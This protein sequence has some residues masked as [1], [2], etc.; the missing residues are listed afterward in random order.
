MS[1]VTVKMLFLSWVMRSG[2]H[3]VTWLVHC[4]VVAPSTACLPVLAPTRI[5]IAS[6]HY[7]HSRFVVDAQPSTLGAVPPSQ[8]V[9]VL[10]TETILS[11]AQSIG[12]SGMLP[13]IAW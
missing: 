4:S 13:S 2:W 5:D 7:T 10:S 6:W 11:G 9:A 1:C 8:A 3:Q 12:C